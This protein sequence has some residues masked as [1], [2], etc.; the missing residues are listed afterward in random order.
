LPTL[1]ILA[2]QVSLLIGGTLLVEKVFGMPGIGTLMINAIGARDL[3]VIQALALVYAVV[4]QCAN[5]TADALEVL[6]N[7][8]LR[9]A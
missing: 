3:P 9:M 2:M 7:P 1:N 8:R 6:L 5:A 4:V